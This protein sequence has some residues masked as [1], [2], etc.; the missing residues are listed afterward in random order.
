VGLA[1]E[2]PA[3]WHRGPV[4]SALPHRLHRHPGDA[5]VICGDHRHWG[6][7]GAA[8]LLLARRGAEGAVIDVV[9]QHRALWSD[10][11]GTW[12][13]PG[14]ALAPGEPAVGGAL[15][16]AEEEASIR[17]GAVRVVG[18]HV[19]DHG[20]WAYTTVVGEI[21]QGATVAPAA[22]DP[23]SLDVRWVS[24]PELTSLPLLPAFATA[25]PA[26]LALLGEDGSLPPHAP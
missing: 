2:V 12:G 1:N 8:G 24:L 5:W 6:T 15:R 16:E 13:V 19:L 7:Y 11:G 25:L 22:S 3:I 17:P 10:Q 23:E 21:A 9:L 18:T 4:T 14:G 26:L 20:P